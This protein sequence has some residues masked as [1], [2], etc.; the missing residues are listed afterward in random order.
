[1][2]GQHIRKTSPSSL[3][4][5]NCE[6]RLSLVRLSKQDSDVKMGT[7]ER[8]TFRGT[9]TRNLSRLPL[10][11]S[12]RK[13]SLADTIPTFLLI[14]RTRTLSSAASVGFR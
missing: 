8:L 9:F 3:E 7:S 2:V 12:C 6:P 5:E 11:H 1:M 4:E 13:R 10:S 14:P